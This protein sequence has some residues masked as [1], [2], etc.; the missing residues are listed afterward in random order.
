[1][2]KNTYTYAGN[3]AMQYIAKMS[4]YYNREKEDMLIDISET[5]NI[6]LNELKDKYLHLD[7]STE[8][9]KQDSEVELIATVLTKK[10]IG[11]T[12]YYLDMENNKIYSKQSKH[13]GNIENGKY[14]FI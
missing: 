14:V 8:T 12:I 7:N 13:V 4:I 2:D 1:M 11:N 6:P 10:K 5:Y 9:N 3:R